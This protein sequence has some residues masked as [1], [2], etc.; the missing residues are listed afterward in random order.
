M[1]LERIPRLFKHPMSGFSVA[2]LHTIAAEIGQMLIE[3]MARIPAVT[4]ISMNFAT[5]TR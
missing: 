4:H 1:R 3:K 2:A 5:T